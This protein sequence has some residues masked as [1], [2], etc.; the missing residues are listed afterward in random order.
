LRTSSKIRVDGLDDPTTAEER[1]GS[2][3]AATRGSEKQTEEQGE[4][5][6]QILS[7]EG[8]LQSLTRSLAWTTDTNLQEKQLPGVFPTNQST[9]R[10]SL[11]LI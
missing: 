11:D 4:G 2:A 10:R 7:W 6:L 5:N 9:E 3:K 8:L 1:D